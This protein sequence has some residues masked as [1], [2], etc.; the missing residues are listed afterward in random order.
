MSPF[1]ENIFLLLGTIIGAG[2]FSLPIALKQSG[3]IFFLITI[4]GLE[5]LLA[6]VNSFYREIVD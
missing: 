3:W 4:I 2:I 1:Y 5:Y 6:K